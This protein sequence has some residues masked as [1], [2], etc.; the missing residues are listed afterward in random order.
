MRFKSAIIMRLKRTEKG[1]PGVTKY[2]SSN[3]AQCWAPTT[4]TPSKLRKI[5]LN[6]IFEL[7]YLKY[8]L[9][10]KISAWTA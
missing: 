10:Y 8:Y 1:L 9:T 6:Y 3:A 2:R 4:K 7:F 5:F